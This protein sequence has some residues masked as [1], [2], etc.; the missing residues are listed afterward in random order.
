MLWHGGNGNPPL[1][2]SEQVVLFKERTRWDLETVTHMDDKL[3]P[4]H[5]S[6]IS[7][8]LVCPETNRMPGSHSSITERTWKID[9]I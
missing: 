4:R 1:I 3:N 7:C 2:V 6:A 5:L 8:Q 9:L